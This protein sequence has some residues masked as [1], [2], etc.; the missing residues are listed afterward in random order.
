M[1]GSDDFR[2]AVT[3]PSQRQVV[4]PLDLAGSLRGCSSIAPADGAEVKRGRPDPILET[5]EVEIEDDEFDL[6]V[7]TR[8]VSEPAPRKRSMGLVA[9]L[10]AVDAGL[11]FSPDISPREQA[12]RK[13]TPLICPATWVNVILCFI[14]LL[15][16]CL[17]PALVD[18]SRTA[19]A[20]GPDGARIPRFPYDAPSVLRAEASFNVGLG[21]TAIVLQRNSGGFAPLLR[22]DFHLMMIP[23]TMVY[24]L[25]DLAALFAIGSGGGLLYVA[26]SNMRLIFAALASRAF[27]GRR[28]S[29]RQWLLLVEI[30]GAAAAYAIL[31][32]R[33]RMGAGE[34]GIFVMAAG[35]CWGVAKAALSGTAA[36]LTE[37]RYKRLN[38]WHANTLLKGQSLLVAVVISWVSSA[39]CEDLPLCGDAAAEGAPWCVDRKG[40]DRWTWAV[41]LAEIATGWLSVAVLTRM[42]AVSKFVCKTA[43]APT[44]YLA[45]C[46]AAPGFQFETS[47]FL[48]VVAI[49]AGIFA[50]TIEPH[51]KAIQERLRGRSWVEGYPR[52]LRLASQQQQQPSPN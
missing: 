24:C 13:K 51:Y 27:L 8:S 31:S 30:T 33:S 50:Y 38:L 10:D 35:T 49:A 22:M 42:S 47:R 9:A 6:P 18:L 15:T 4:P 5:I 39:S 40:W 1:W 44:L 17:V 25:G 43:T 32:S 2:R 12:R 46:A 45:Y 3:A 41:L 19:T 14:S 52:G 36:V 7:R 29:P 20:I 26:V 11:P 23:L 37:S 34:Q 21:L 28:Q 48:A 16:G